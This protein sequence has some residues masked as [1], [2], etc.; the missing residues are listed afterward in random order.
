VK[1]FVTIEGEEFEV[2]VD[3][4]RVTVG[5][6]EFEAHLRA[7]PGTPVRHLLLDDLSL[8][9]PVEAVGKGRWALAYHGDRWEVEV[10]DQR[11]RHVRGLTADRSVARG[12][13]ALRAPMPGLVVRLGASAGQTVTPGQGIVVLEAMKMENELRAVAGGVVKLVLVEPGQAVE[14]GQVL[15][16]FQ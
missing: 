11:T 12:P 3:G 1:Y 10:I 16:E 2:S 8:T 14:K 6:R 13:S 7:V 4:A 15:V 9:V 5:A